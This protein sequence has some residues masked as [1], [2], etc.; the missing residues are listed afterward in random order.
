MAVGDGHRRSGTTH[1]LDRLQVAVVKPSCPRFPNPGDGNGGSFIG[2]G[3]HQLFGCGDI[4]VGTES[5]EAEVVLQEGDDGVVV[6]VVRSQADIDDDGGRGVRHGDPS[7]QE[8]GD[9]G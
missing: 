9:M 6:T 4:T 5:N 7:G 3:V 1:P 2:P 8:R